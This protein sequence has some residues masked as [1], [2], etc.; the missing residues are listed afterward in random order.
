MEIFKGVK[1]KHRGNKK[2]RQYRYE[3]KLRVVRLY[4]EEGFPAL[5]IHKETGVAKET[6]WRWIR[7]YKA[8]GEEGL[9][10][11]QRVKRGSKQMPASVKEKIIEVKREHPAYGVRRISQVLRRL[12]FLPASPESIRRTLHQESLISPPQKR[13]RRNISKPRFFERSSPNQ[14]W[15]GDIFTF[16]L[17]G[18]NA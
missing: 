12:F 16:R 18:K 11:R 5:L 3:F 7:V 8:K 10:S 17:G 6:L 2:A 14:M 13:S 9:K 4:L 1:K 15:Q